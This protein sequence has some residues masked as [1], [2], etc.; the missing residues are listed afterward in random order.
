[1]KGTR[2]PHPHKDPRQP[3]GLLALRLPLS[4]LGRLSPALLSQMAHI[5]FV[6]GRLTQPASSLILVKSR[7]Q[8]FLIFHY[9]AR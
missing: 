8:L 1:M 9:P 4:R 6:S 2:H 3:R 7:P 5:S